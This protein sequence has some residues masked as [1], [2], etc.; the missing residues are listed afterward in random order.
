MFFFLTSSFLLLILCFRSSAF[1]L[2]TP[3]MSSIWYYNLQSSTLTI[4]VLHLKTTSALYFS[5][6]RRLE[7]PS[8]NAGHFASLHGNRSE[9]FFPAPSFT[10]GHLTYLQFPLWYKLFNV[11][12]PY[13]FATVT[14]QM[15]KKRKLRNLS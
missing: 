14:S 10:S 8:V 5:Q 13:L 11:W 7:W 4:M 2:K 15:E 12:I 9:F 1:Q 6:A 3:H